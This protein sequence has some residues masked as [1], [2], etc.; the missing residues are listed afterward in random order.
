M[1]KV[2]SNKLTALV[3]ILLR[4]L[5]QWIHNGKGKQTQT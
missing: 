2:L 4:D 1:T 5:M 3:L